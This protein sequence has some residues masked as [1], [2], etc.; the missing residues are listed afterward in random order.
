MFFTDE[1][2]RFHKSCCDAMFGYAGALTAASS[3][4]SVQALGF[5]NEALNVETERPRSKNRSRSARSTQV[6]YRRERLKGRGSRRFVH[7]RPAVSS[8][9]PPND[10]FGAFGTF[11]AMPW[12]M[13][14]SLTKQQGSSHFGAAV[15]Q[16]GGPLAGMPAYFNPASMMGAWLDMDWTRVP[17][18]WPM[19][20]GMMAAGVPK[21]VAWPMAEANLAVMDA[22]TIAGG[23][24]HRVFGNGKDTRGLDVSRQYFENL[25]ALGGSG[26]VGR[27]VRPVVPLQFFSPY[28]AI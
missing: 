17:G 26:K 13:A 20:Y 14:S 27:T 2:I 5:W 9:E 21:S 7:A 15:S 23:A 25:T 10:I 3:I 4:M 28:F 1:Q 6:I 12:L 19:A 8:S 22:M 18:C 24:A 16:A 11:Y